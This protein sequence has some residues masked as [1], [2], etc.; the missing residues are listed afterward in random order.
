MTLRWHR[1]RSEQ[2]C[3]A[4]TSLHPPCCLCWTLKKVSMKLSG[5]GTF[6]DIWLR[7]SFWT[8][9]PLYPSVLYRPQTHILKTYHNESFLMF[10]KNFAPDFR[11]FVLMALQRCCEESSLLRLNLVSF[12][13]RMLFRRWSDYFWYLLVFLVVHSSKWTPCTYTFDGILWSFE[14]FTK[15]SLFVKMPWRC[16][17]SLERIMCSG[18]PLSRVLRRRSPPMQL[19]WI[20]SF[21]IKL[22]KI[23]N[24]TLS[25]NS[26][27]VHCSFTLEPVKAEW[28]CNRM[29]QIPKTHFSF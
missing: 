8:D 4:S 7:R 13:Q 24:K 2:K 29:A 19:L 23:K 5:N 12:V 17:S 16:F 28:L 25:F 10:I 18:L 6:V 15:F 3:S 21:F 14:T 27:L 22:K 1:S 26:L 11:C 9:F 20:N